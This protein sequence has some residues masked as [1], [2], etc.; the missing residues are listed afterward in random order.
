MK[1]NI[2]TFDRWVRIIC[3]TIILSFL[4]VGPQSLWGLIGAFPLVTGIAAHCPFYA[5]C[6]FS[7]DFRKRLRHSAA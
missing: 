4:F 2:G 3:G 5:M 1:V 7:T 6:D